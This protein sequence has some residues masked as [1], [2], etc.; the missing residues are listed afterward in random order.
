M[1]RLVLP[2]FLALPLALLAQGQRAPRP[3]PGLATPGWKSTLSISFAADTAPSPEPILY[4]DGDGAGPPRRGHLERS[5][6]VRA[7][8]THA[9]LCLSGRAA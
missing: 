2:L 4:L 6:R 8:R 5:T 7:S 1:R 3:G 9:D